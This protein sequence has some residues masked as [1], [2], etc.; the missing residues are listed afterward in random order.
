MEIILFLPIILSLMMTLLVVPKWIRKCRQIELLWPDMNKY[1]YPKKV[2]SSGGIVIILAFV[3]GVLS[4]VALETFAL[5]GNNTLNVKIF[6]FLNVVILA[7]LIGLVDDFLGWQKGGL[8]WRFRILMAFIISI[9]L[10]VINVGDHIMSIPFF[11]QVNFGIFYS[12]LIIPLG[13][14]GTTTTFNFLAGFNGLEAGQGIIIVGFLSF[15]AYITGNS[16]LAIMGLIMVASLIGFYFYNRFP[17]RVF[18]GNGATWA[19]GSMIACMAILGN[20]EK[21]AVFIFI[22]YI[23]ESF[24]KAGRGKLKKQSFGIPDKKNSLSLPYKKI[25]GLTHFSIFILSKFKKE[26]KEQD[27]IYFIW[28]FQILICFLGLIIFRTSLF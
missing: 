27:V 21:I 18:P 10:V 11:G 14:A 13:V 22:P 26:V 2:A 7:G 28:I 12:L 20:F 8:S 25:Y 5:D 4:Y 6:S 19:I 15:I 23:I 24:L 9:P 1:G 16:W 17:A 3:L